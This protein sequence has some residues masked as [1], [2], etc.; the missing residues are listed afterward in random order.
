EGARVFVSDAR[1]AVDVGETIR[2]LDEMGAAYEFGGRTDRVL[3]A[4]V[5]VLSPGVPDTIPIVRRA[6]ERGMTITN[7]IEIAWRRCRGRVVAITGTN[8]KTTTA[9]LTGHILRTAGLRTYVAGNVG[10]PFSEIALDA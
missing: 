6:G 9:E 4:D 10:L 2:L 3:D 8:G 7:E 5:L 1:P